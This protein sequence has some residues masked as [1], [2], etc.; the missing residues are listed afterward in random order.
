MDPA[1]EGPVPLGAQDFMQIE[2][3]TVGDIDNIFPTDSFQRLKV[4]ARFGLIHNSMTCP[5]CGPNVQ[6]TL[7]KDKSEADGY[8]VCTIL[9][10]FIYSAYN[11]KLHFGFIA[12]GMPTM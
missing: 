5:V 6:M 4:L 3:N 2:V 7:Q 12:V 11:N 10:L 1:L 9:T 8:I